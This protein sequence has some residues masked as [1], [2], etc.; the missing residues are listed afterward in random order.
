MSRGGTV[1]VYIKYPEP[2]RVKTRLAATIGNTEAARLY[3]CW[4]GEVLTAVQSLRPEIQLV[5]A[6]DGA[7]AKAFQQWQPLVDG[8][9]QQ[10]EG[11]LGVRLDAGF[12]H[13]HTTGQ[14]V[15]AIGTDCLEL[16]ATLV[17]DGFA[18]L[19]RVDAVFGPTVDG[20]YYL[21]GTARYLPG[22]FSG[23]RWSTPD[24][25]Q[26]HL[27]R[28][29]EHHWQYQ[30]LPMRQDVDTWDEWLAYCHKIGRSPTA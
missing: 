26:D 15:V 28:C 21:V 30:L 12:R 14:P 23:I 4:I 17:L 8:W 9:W 24:T 29:Q 7:E 10:P 5:G 20:G 19:D 6:I 25:L 16:N 22:F 18:A 3:R 2:G 11:D 27:S 13:A 1:L